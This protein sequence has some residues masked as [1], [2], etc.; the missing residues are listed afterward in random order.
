[1]KTTNR[2]EKREKKKGWMKAVHLFYLKEEAIWWAVSHA[3]AKL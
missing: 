2:K 1:M 3:L